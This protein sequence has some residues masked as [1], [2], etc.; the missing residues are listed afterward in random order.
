VPLGYVPEAQQR[1]EIYRKLA[2]ATEK[3]G[4]EALTGEIRDRYGALPG[5]VALLLQ[6]YELKLLAA[7]RGVNLIE[8]R[9]GKLMLSRRGQ[10][11]MFGGKFPRLSKPDAAGRLREIKKLLL[12]L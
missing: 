6:T 11:V 7:E 5:A 9:D 4:I 3:K 12:A 8:T 10:Y 2:Q 1:I